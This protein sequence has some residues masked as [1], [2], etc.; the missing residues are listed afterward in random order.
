MLKYSDIQIKKNKETF[1][2]TQSYN[3]VLYVGEWHLKTYKNFFNY[4]NFTQINSVT[5]PYDR[6]VDAMSLNKPLFRH[7]EPFI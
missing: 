5:G 7:L 1:Q 6:C 4:L 2:P 3:I